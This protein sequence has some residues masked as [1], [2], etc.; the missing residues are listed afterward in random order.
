MV[1][2]RVVTV[3]VA[4]KPF[5]KKKGRARELSQPLI[6]AEIIHLKEKEGSLDI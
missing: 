5:G 2:Q 3:F 6:E 4:L 1:M